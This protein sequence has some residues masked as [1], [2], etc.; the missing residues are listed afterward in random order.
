MNSMIPFGN[1]V[2][3]PGK[4]LAV[5]AC[6][7]Q[8]RE[9]FH[10][11]APPMPTA[12]TT[13][14]TSYVLFSH[15]DGFTW[16]NPVRIAKRESGSPDYGYQIPSILRL[17]ANRWFAAIDNANNVD[18]FVSEDEGRAWK[19]AGALT[20]RNQR[21]GNLRRL[22]DGRILLTYALRERTHF[23]H[24][25]DDAPNYLEGTLWR[26]RTREGVTEA[27]LPERKPERELL[28]PHTGWG[29]GCIA[30]RISEDEGLSWQSTRLV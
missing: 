2:Q 16:G 11:K 1:I 20:L 28:Q 30:Y 6:D 3:G 10:R 22:R 7:L 29:P 13:E 24:P 18:L 23:G 21:P 17:G 8:W 12:E 25:Q 27:D 14:A 15:D 4:T 5:G 9:E 19:K 26:R